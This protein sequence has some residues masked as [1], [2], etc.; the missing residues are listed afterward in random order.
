MYLPAVN[1]D[2][3]SPTVDNDSDV[4]DVDE[5]LPLAMVNED[6]IAVDEHFREEVNEVLDE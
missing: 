4:A 5:V 3:T 2:N 1:E 6:L